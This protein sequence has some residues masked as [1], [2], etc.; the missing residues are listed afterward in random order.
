[1]I[2]D[3]G[4]HG[5]NKAK[6]G[7]TEEEAECVMCG[8][9]DGQMHWMV[10]CGHA[11]C[12]QLRRWGKTRMYDMISELG[13]GRDKEFRLAELI[14]DWAWSRERMPAAFGRDSGARN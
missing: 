7:C 13:H 1:M 5:W 6:G 8:L 11:A 4:W 3:K 2:W 10:E 9:P 14:V 12:V